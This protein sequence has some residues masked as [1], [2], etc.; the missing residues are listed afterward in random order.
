MFVKKNSTYKPAMKGPGS[1]SPIYFANSKLFFTVY[2][3]VVIGSES[4][5]KKLATL[6]VGDLTNDI[7]SINGG[8]SP[9]EHLIFEMGKKRNTC[10]WFKN[11]S[12]LTKRKDF[13][14]IIFQMRF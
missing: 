14:D 7:I 10:W 12:N 3:L 5:T 2:I 8:H 1:W 6:Y 9:I 11:N 4:G 13:T